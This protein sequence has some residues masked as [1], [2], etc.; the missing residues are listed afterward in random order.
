MRRTSVLLFAVSCSVP[1][2]HVAA[3][4]VDTAVLGS[5]TDPSGSVI[6][7]A[8]VTVHSEATGA[9]KS[10]TTASSG[11]YNIQYL[12]PGP[13][14]VTVQAPGFAQQ[15]RKGVILALQQQIH[16]NFALTVGASNDVVEV[17]SAIPLQQTENAS[18]GTTVDTNR[19]LNLPLN[20]RRFND[21]AVLTPGVTVSN[22]D[23]HSSSTAGSAVGANGGRNRWG[24]VD[25][26]GITLLNNRQAY[27]NS[28]PSVDA[29]EEFR[30]QTGNFAAQY[31][32]SAGSNISVQLKSGTD[33]FH[34]S[35]FE[36][37][38]NDAVDARNYFRAAPLRKNVLRQNQF[39]ATVG[40]PIL[41][42]KT[43]FFL[44]YEGLRS[45][46][47]VPSLTT[48]LT[49]AQRNG[50]FSAYAGV[51]RNPYTNLPYANKAALPVNA[52]AQALVNQYMPLPNGSFT[53]GTNYSGASIGNESNDQG[54]VRLDHRFSDHDSIFVHYIIGNRRFPNTAIN[55]NFRYNA[56]YP[57]HNA[58]LQYLHVFSP[59]LI[60]EFRGGA[61]I[62]HVKLLSVRTGTGFTIESLG[63]NGFKVGGPNGRALTPNEEGFPLLTISGFI[64][65]GDSAA[66]S[67]LDYSRTF[68][69]ADNVT[70]TRGKHTFLIG[71][72]DRLAADNAT[73]NNTPFGQESFTGDETG[74]A[75]AD[76]II[77]VP[78]TSITPEGVPIT[79][80]RQWR[81]SEYA[82]DNWRLTDKLTLNLGLRYE[83]YSPPVDLNN[84]SR[85]LDYSSGQ[86]VLTP[87][88]GQR[89]NNLWTITH[90]DIAPRLGFA[91]NVLKGTV[92]RGGFGLT[93]FGGQF[94]N[95]N[96]LQLNPPT[97]GSLTITNPR[98]SG[99]DGLPVA[100]ITTPVPAA[101]YPANPFFNVVSLPADRRHPDPTLATY[102]VAVSQQIGRAVLDTTYVGT[103]GY[104][105]DTSIQYYNSPN[106]GSTAAIQPRRPYPAYARIRQLDFTGISNYDSLQE[107]LEYRVT[108][109]SN[110]TA[111]YVWSHERD[112]QGF[113]VNSGGC[114]CQDVRHPHEYA[115][116][117]T[118]QRHNFVFAYVYRLPDF[119]RGKGFG[120]LA[121]GWTANGLVTLA[122][123]TPINIVSSADQ[124]NIDNPWQ[125][126][127]LTGVASYIA[128]KSQRAG[129]INPAAFSPIPA[130]SARF[131][132]TPRNYLVGPPTRVVNVSLSKDLS[133]VEGQ[134]LQIRFE[135]FN[136]LNTPQFSN[137]NA[138]YGPTN[139]GTITSTKI[140]NRELQLAAKYYF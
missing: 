91:Y 82:Q 39:G 15:Q 135:A 20:G 36:F 55:P 123:G 102:N 108:A 22:P 114:T 31:G 54:I 21:L 1:C 34:G 116:G 18:L 75:A 30:V 69:I 83:I 131:G 137:P 68:M 98:N 78:R 8:I 52:V 6:A 70:Y 47:E 93:Y 67:N 79:A 90:K 124:L 97:A 37:I 71:T 122:S 57:M 38:R 59:S 62:E 129:W 106:P 17:T 100:T 25:V 23:N 128:G 80:A 74:Y 77:G 5:V 42:G 133:F 43:F 2:L 64:G 46:Q 120:L 13:Y 85:T 73:T 76:Y 94:D 45:I 112:D 26:D 44:S 132:T 72:D 130:G 125:R 29:I 50:D 101:L 10:A 16:L 28:Y 63:I 92:L 117:G 136:A 41:R 87:A 99:S 107:H 119:V 27:V 139:F 127:D 110:I 51:L 61:N 19:I 134:S 140:N 4:S 48:V 115:T 138:G 109:R 35:F 53:G 111:S 3:Q 89:L 113:D 56:T 33:K 81:T 11:E 24:S 95:I 9:E 32:F 126:P 121:N 118:D 12:V 14:T 86:P 84:V 40:G 49:S 105:L 65:V 58:A 60:N 88:P 103:H 96:I 66:S 7:G 104:N